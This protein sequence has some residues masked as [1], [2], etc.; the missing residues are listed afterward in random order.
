MYKHISGRDALCDRLEFDS[1]NSMLTLPAMKRRQIMRIVPVGHALSTFFVITF[2]ICI[3]WGLLTPPAMHM[4]QAWEMM[5]PGFHWLS[6][7]AFLIGLIWA[8]VYGWYTAIV[9]VPLY[10]LFNK[11]GAAA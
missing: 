7:P 9:F 8:Y 11:R 1:A 5:M 6:F 3:G 10:N 4:H 2:A